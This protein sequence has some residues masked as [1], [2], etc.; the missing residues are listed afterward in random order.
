M[1][2]F[3]YFVSFSPL[4]S[5]FCAWEFP[6]E[7]YLYTTVMP[8]SDF[9]S[10]VL[11]ILFSSC[12]FSWHCWQWCVVELLPASFFFF[13]I[14]RFTASLPIAYLSSYLSFFAVAGGVHSDGHHSFL[15]P[16]YSSLTLWKKFIMSQEKFLMACITGIVIWVAADW[17]LE[18]NLSTWIG[19]DITNAHGRLIVQL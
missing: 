17:H 13:L 2:V 18:N 19:L 10:F 7:G 11:T 12:I 8:S 14:D 9:A 6:P 15:L 16:V 3:C 5:L 1:E 4:F